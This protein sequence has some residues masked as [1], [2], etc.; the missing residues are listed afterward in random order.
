M[1]I[2][3]E[4][5]D[6]PFDQSDEPDLPL[7]GS[8]GGLPAGGEPAPGFLSQAGSPPPTQIGAESGMPGGEG[9]MGMGEEL[10]DEDLEVEALQQ[11]LDD[12]NT[13]P[14]MKALLEQQLAIA[15]RRRLAGMGGAGGGGLGGGGLLG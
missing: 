9:L 2:G 8:G 3:A 1:P 7:F 4:E 13:P 12:P 15:A 11:M 6:I 10:S 14:Q 5:P